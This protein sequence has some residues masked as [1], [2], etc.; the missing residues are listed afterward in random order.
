MGNNNSCSTV[1]IGSILLKPHDGM[2][3]ELKDVRCVPSMKKS[4]I[5]LG[6]LESKGYR[7][8]G[9]NGV[10]KVITRD[11]V[12]MK[13]TRHHNLYYFNGSIDNKLGVHGIETI[14]VGMKKGVKRFKLRDPFTKKMIISK[15]VMF[16]EAFMLNPKSSQQ[17]ENN[18]SNGKNLQRVKFDVVTQVLDEIAPMSPVFEEVTDSG[19]ETDEGTNDRESVDES[20]DE[21]KIDIETESNVPKSIASGRPKREIRKPGWFRDR[22]GF[23][24]TR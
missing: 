7:L 20:E 10:M 17:V 19:V 6:M 23:A 9:Q 13:G 18:T 4:M 24:A 14:F 11:M 21:T 12:V 3:R 22:R 15:D 2:V 16:N 5:S 1:G 8:D